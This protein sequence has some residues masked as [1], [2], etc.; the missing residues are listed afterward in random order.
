M[1]HLLNLHCA[2]FDDADV[3]K[4]RKCDTLAAVISLL[5]ESQHLRYDTILECIIC[6]KSL[7]SD[8]CVWV[9]MTWRSDIVTRLRERLHSHFQRYEITRRGDSSN[10]RTKSRRKNNAIISGR[11]RRAATPLSTTR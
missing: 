1:S 9:Q 5:P 11:T 3:D 8:S 10:A 4:P 6:P 7:D 2:R